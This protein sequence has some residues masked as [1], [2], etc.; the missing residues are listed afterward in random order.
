MSP[1]PL[2]TAFGAPREGIFRLVIGRGL[3]LSGMGIV[4]GLGIALSLTRVM[5]SMLVGVEPTDPLT[6]VVISLVFAGLAA[7]ACWIPARRAAALDPAEA[8][9]DE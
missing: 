2:S 9:R 6:F 7:I 5:R 1:R 8:L 4:I 3:V